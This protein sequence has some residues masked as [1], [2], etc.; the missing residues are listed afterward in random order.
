MP[1]DV[2]T[3]RLTHSCQTVQRHL[4]FRFFL[5]L[6]MKVSNSLIVGAATTILVSAVP[7]LQQLHI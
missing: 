3:Q 4:G 6:T 1:Y 7:L 5:P 2:L